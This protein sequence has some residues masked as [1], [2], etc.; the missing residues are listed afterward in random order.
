MTS[1]RGRK[2]TEDAL[3]ELNHVLGETHH[4]K[5]SGKEFVAD[6]MRKV[7]ASV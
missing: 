3:E 6:C 1:I 5:A 7:M 4:L 2:F